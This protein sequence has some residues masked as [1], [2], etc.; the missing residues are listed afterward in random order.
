MAAKRFQRPFDYE[1][2]CYILVAYRLFRKQQTFQI[3]R[4]NLQLFQINRFGVL[5]Q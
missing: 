3:D 2:V 5:L 1:A 4:S